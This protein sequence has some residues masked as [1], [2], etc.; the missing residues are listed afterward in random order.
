MLD[1]LLLS[2]GYNAAVAMIG[3]TLLGIA[4]GPVGVFM[5]LRRRALLADAASHATLPGIVLAFLVNL[6]LT[7]EGRS[8]PVLLVGAGAAA[9]LGV[10][11]VQALQANSRLSG[12]TAIAVV[13]SGAFGLGV[14]GL[15][16]VQTLPVAGQAG[17]D[18]FLV[19]QTAGMRLAD[20]Y[21]I[22]GVAAVL[23]I[24]IA[25]LFK[26]LRLIA[27]DPEF[28]A[29]AGWPVQR[30]DLLANGLLLATVVVGLTS[31]G[32]VLIVAMLII[33]AVTARLWTQKLGRMALLAAVFGGVSAY[34][35]AAASAGI[36]H[37]PTGATI[38]LA[39]A[40]LF[41]VSLPIAPLSRPKRAPTALEPPV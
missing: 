6:W 5:L 14:M 4:A 1:A 26:E 21:L 37:L 2:S 10:L 41:A 28:A 23:V 12:P 15:S 8:L 16:Y 22:A 39:A 18:Q 35:G 3:A 27:F 17:L 13:L 29:A 7:G 25:L 36:H 34:L 11:A 9:A 40:A 31:V 24:V 38:V 19:G 30:L 32:L 20:A 33:P